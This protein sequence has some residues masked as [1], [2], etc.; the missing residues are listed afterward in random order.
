VFNLSACWRA[1]ISQ[2]HFVH[3]AGHWTG[4]GLG[5]IPAGDGGGVALS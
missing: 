3:K 2:I 1:L 4:I 5:F